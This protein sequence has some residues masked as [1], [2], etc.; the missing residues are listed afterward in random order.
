[1]FPVQG[2]GVNLDHLVNSLWPSFPI[3]A[4]LPAIGIG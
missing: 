4:Q 1:M 3:Y 2:L